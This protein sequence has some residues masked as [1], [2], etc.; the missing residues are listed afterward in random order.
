MSPAAAIQ[1]VSRRDRAVVGGA[2][3]GIVVLAWTYILL[4]AAWT[5]P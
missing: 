1:W 2:L 5:P 4:G 3:A